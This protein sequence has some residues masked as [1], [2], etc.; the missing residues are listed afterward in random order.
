MA[1][2]LLAAFLVSAQLLIAAGLVRGEPIGWVERFAL[3]DDREAVLSELIPGTDDHYFYH[4]LHYQTIGDVERA[5]SVLADWLQEKNGQSTPMIRAMTDRQRLLTYGAT[6]ERTVEHLVR[7]LGIRL[8]HPAPAATGERRR[9]SELDGDRLT[10]ERLVVEGIRVG[11]QLRPAGLRFLGARFVAGETAGLPITLAELLDRVDGPYLDD[12]DR[13]VIA[14]LQSRRPN[15]RRFGDRAAHAH[16]TLAELKRVAEAVP[17]VA[18]DQAMVH[19]TLRRLRP[20]ADRDP[21]QQ[22]DVRLDY[23]RRV[24]AYTRTLP[25]SHDGLK[26]AA[27]FRLLEANLGEG[28]FDRALLLRYLQLPRNSPIIRDE[29]LRRQASRVDLNQDFMDVAL[30]S[31]IGDERG[32]VRA[33]LEHFLSDAA[34]AS[35][36]EPYVRPEYLRR[37]F[38][39]SK[40]LA[41]VEPADRWYRM[42]SPA[43]RQAIR[44]KVVL[45]LAA[46]N[47][48]RYRGDEPVELL[49]DVKN[50]DELTVRVYEINSLAYYRTRGELIDTDIDLDGLVATSE[51]QIEYSHAATVRHRERIEFP[52]LEGRGVWVIDLVGGGVR[53]RA[54]I[55]R[56]E[57][58]HVRTATADGMAWTI[59]DEFREPVPSAAMIL[60]GREFAADDGARIVMPPVA[61]PTERRGVIHDGVI[62]ESVTFTHRQEE[63]TLTAGF[64]LDRALLQGGGQ[65]ELLIRPRLMLDDTPVDPAT[66]SAVQV[67]LVA[68]DADGISTTRV[69]DDLTLT[70]TGELSVPFRVPHRLARLRVDVSGQLDRISDGQRQTLKAGRTWELSGIRE[71]DQTRDAFLTRDGEAFVIEVRGRTGEPVPGAMVSLSF[72]TEVR[73]GWLDETL[74]TDDRG[75]VRLTDLPGVRRIRFGVTGGLDHERDLRLDAAT[76][77]GEVHTAAGSTIRL[78][79]GFAVDDP[80]ERYRL[81]AVRDGAVESDVTD[82][83]AGKAGLLQIEGLRPGDYRLI[84]RV[85]GGTTLV[86]VVDGPVIDSVVAGRIRHRQLPYAQPLGI[87][88]VV[89]GEEEWRVTLSGDT[90]ATR[91]HVHAKRYFGP[92]SSFDEFALDPLPL[93]G[94]GVRLPGC[95]YVSDLRLGDEYRYV[96]RRR[97]AAKYPGVM[98]P[99]PGLLLNPWETEETTNEGQTAA[100]GQAV[101]RSDA[102]AAPAAA[103][104]AERQAEGETGSVESDYDFLADPGVLLANL[105]PDKDGVVTI[106]ADAVEGMPIVQVIACDQATVVQRTLAGSLED[107]ETVDLRLAESLAADQPLTFERSVSIVSP[108][109]PLELAK[110]GRGQLQVIADARGLFRLYQTLVEDPRFEEFEPL[111]RWDELDTKGRMAAYTRLASHETHLFLWA[112]DREFF[113]QTIRPYLANKKEKQFVDR[114]LL[115]EDLSDYDA[116]WRYGR[117][118]AAEKTLLAVRSAEARPGVIREFRE[119]IELRDDDPMLLRKLIESALAGERLQENLR[120]GRGAEADADFAKDERAAKASSGWAFGMGGMGGGIG[121]GNATAGRQSGRSKNVELAES[122]DRSGNAR[123]LESMPFRRRSSLGRSLAFFRN[124]DSTKQW[125]ESQWDRVRTAGRESPEMLIPIDPFWLDVASAT[126]VEAS[127]GVPGWKPSAEL[128]RPVSNRH[129][130]LMALAVC[131]LPLG[132]PSFEIPAGADETFVPPQDVAVVT[133]RLRPLEAV[134]EGAGVLVGQ[135]FSDPSRSGRDVPE[136]EEYLTGAAYRGEV[137]ISNPTAEAKQVEVFWQIP[138]G[139]LP[140]GGGRA[141]DSRTVKLEPLAVASVSY[142]FYFPS[143]GDFEHYPATVAAEGRLLG[144]GEAR[145]FPVVAEPS[146]LDPESW[147]S[148]ARRGTADEIKTFLQDANLRDL[149]WDRVAHRM[150]DNDV[151][152]V[153]TDALHAAKLDEPELWGYGFHHRDEAAM[154]AYLSLRDDLVRDVGPVLR[155]ELLRVDPVERDAIEHL[156]Y[157]PLVRGRTHRLGEDDEILNPTFLAHYREFMKVLSFQPSLEKEQMLAVAVY[158]LA[159][160]RIEE[161]LDRFD[162]VD[163]DSVETKLQYD[164]LAGYLA[165]HREDFAAA[166]SIVSRYRDYPV[167]RW[168]ER[169]AEMDIH[170]RQRSTLESVEQLVTSEDDSAIPADAADLAVWDRERRQE[171]AADEQ[172]EVLVEVEGNGLRID[173]RRAKEVTLKLYGVDLEQLFSKAPFVRDGLERMAMVRPT[174]SEVLRFDRATGV[175]RFD[176]D[177]AMRRQT[178]LV[179]VVAGGSR[180]TALY[181][182]GEIKTY[183]SESYGQLQ[184]TDSRT[185]RP[186]SKA[187][188]KVFARYPD[189]DVRFYKDGYTDARGR[190]DYASISAG[191][192]RGASRFAIL[193]LDQERGASLH[194]VAPPNG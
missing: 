110:I 129:A 4:V 188:V 107:P 82:R 8:R 165:M 148:I 97:Y 23:L 63:Y 1:L 173:H 101:P 109:S 117:L 11:D 41:G 59:L 160:N 34:D 44:D 71:T 108:D 79:I 80:G 114:W 57:L 111:V 62:A 46:E 151:Y 42:L 194:D 126:D 123:G 83:I 119:R 135:R 161:A 105:V 96:L 145:V 7:R 106:P 167:P 27:S 19:A 5:E 94:R 54:L 122:E 45:R 163:R 169:F 76:W 186:V 31:A 92:S 147:E 30:I 78:P 174:Q 115:G 132:S 191:A 116:A 144:R 166:E 172:P 112:H 37:V 87:A 179:E 185:R 120:R 133:K 175:S 99:R 39:E 180:S 104:R 70:Q 171:R 61:D 130:A 155:S 60:A 21:S 181:Y 38:A 134:E 176:F 28:T 58:H 190:F 102:P 72:Q 136:P 143:A 127:G 36:F 142:S 15:E 131:G 183:V 146:R 156:E 140:L 168:Q 17:A 16:L 128:L 125:A 47:R 193:V 118:N 154:R 85:T 137:V 51:R 158:L 12:A 93:H 52:E 103:S 187:Y 73:E 68:T 184:C 90:S 141:T 88:S 18:A 66:L 33:H 74:Q 84:D 157:A 9:P 139:S 153:V 55:R 20:D 81:L 124:L 65:A 49:A 29:Y 77:P 53:A 32:V 189:G 35:A 25:A 159:Q 22:E 98:L 40:L 162:R 69:L 75:R 121:R 48:E 170:L 113:D 91:V 64:A 24:E 56:G 2:R 138:Q 164:Y 86:A 67:N 149:A 50:V 43:E 177:E 95:G 13:L 192:A 6:P 14:E 100:P 150:R 10:T 89:R 178:M 182:G 26:A 3:A 152:T